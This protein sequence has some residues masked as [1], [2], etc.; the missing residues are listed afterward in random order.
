MRFK[1]IVVGIFFG[2]LIVVGISVSRD[3]G[4]PW[5]E[6]IQRR[7]GT[8]VYN[9]VFGNDEKLLKNKDRY[10]GPVLEFSL[11]FFEKTFNLTD[12]KVIYQVRHMVNYLFFVVGVFFFY[13]LLLKRFRS[14]W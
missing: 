1:S 10:Y 6:S 4:I 3:Y 2:L 8:D 14:I 13:L 11:V 5:G 12:A 9:Y 7:L